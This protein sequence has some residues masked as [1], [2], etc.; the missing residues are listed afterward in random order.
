MDQEGNSAS[1]LTM[2]QI[3][4]TRR[5]LNRI[6][7]LPESQQPLVYEAMLACASSLEKGVCITGQ[8]AMQGSHDAKGRGSGPVKK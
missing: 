6:A 7:A 5:I 3:A 1:T 8:K 4:N 2:E